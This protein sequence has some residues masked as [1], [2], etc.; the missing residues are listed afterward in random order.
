[1]VIWPPMGIEVMTEKPNV[2]VLLLD[3]NLLGTRSS[4][5][6]MTNAVPASRVLPSARVVTPVGARSTEVLTVSP[7][8]AA[9]VAP[10][11]V[12]DPTANSNNLS[13]PAVIAAVVVQTIVS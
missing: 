6:V 4:A 13:A 3:E 11:M 10:P 12:T 2:M 1:M 5:L 7:V 9:A 8:D